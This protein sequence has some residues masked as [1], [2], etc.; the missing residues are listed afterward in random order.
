MAFLPTS[1][2]SSYTPL[3]KVSNRLHCSD[4]C[5][6]QPKTHFVLYICQKNEFC[7]VSTWP[8]E[9]YALTGSLSFTCQ[10]ILEIRGGNHLVNHSRCI[11]ITEK[12]NKK[13][14]RQDWNIEIWFP[15]PGSPG[16]Q[17]LQKLLLYILRDR[18]AHHIVYN[19][20]LQQSSSV[21]RDTEDQFHFSRSGN[22][23]PVFHI[24]LP[25][26]L[27]GLDISTPYLEQWSIL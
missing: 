8:L 13:R 1:R 4:I 2:I 25:E 22:F 23:I 17:D 9:C 3:L 10:A 7:S 14:Q 12:K 27:Y 24:S 20:H 15:C 16:R 5:Q 11:Y 26:P 6:G 19:Y 21:P 18:R